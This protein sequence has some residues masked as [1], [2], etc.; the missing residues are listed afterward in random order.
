MNDNKIYNVDMKLYANARH[1]LFHELDSNTD[2]HAINDL[3][4]WITKNL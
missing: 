2:Y 1:D 3:L 4:K